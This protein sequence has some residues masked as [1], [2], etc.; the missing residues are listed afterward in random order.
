MW[1]PHRRHR[2]R[3]GTAV[4]ATPRTGLVLSPAVD[5]VFALQTGRHAR[6][7]PMDLDDPLI[8][9]RALPRMDAR[10]DDVARVVASGASSQ[11]RW[12]RCPHAAS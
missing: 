6:N 1:Q 12:V 8:A 9:G 10:T 7:P 3:P 4:L 5:G 11:S 2:R